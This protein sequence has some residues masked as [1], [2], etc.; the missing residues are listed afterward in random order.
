MD[1]G[2]RYGVD[3]DPDI[4]PDAA[5]DAA[6]PED[7]RTLM[8]E[9]DA[10]IAWLVERVERNMPVSDVEYLIGTYAIECRQRGSDT[11][12]ASALWGELS[13]IAQRCRARGTLAPRE[14]PAPAKGGMAEND[15]GE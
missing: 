8:R 7:A 15:G 10:R 11:P 13:A 2:I 5:F 3:V 6:M 9:C 12:R 4:D 1:M 14:W